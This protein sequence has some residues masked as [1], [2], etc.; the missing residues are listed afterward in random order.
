MNRRTFLLSAGATAVL[1]AFR[2]KL[3]FAKGEAAVPVKAPKP[4][5]EPLLAPWKGPYGGVP[6]FDK[7]KVKDFKPALMKGMDLSRADIKAIT[8]SKDA[9]TFENTIAAFEDSGRHY[10]RAG[11][12]FGTFTSTMNDK[13]MQKVQKEMAPVMAAFSDEIIQNE[14]LFARIKTVYDGRAKANLTP[15]Q[16]RLVEKHYTSFARQGAALNKDQKAKLAEINKKLAEAF[17]A[18]EQNQLHDEESEQ[19]VIDK[20]EDLAGLPESIRGA[21]KAAADAKKLKGKWVITNTRSSAEPFLSYSSRRDLREKVFKMWNSRGDHDGEHDNKPVMLQILALR[22]ERAKLLGFKSHAHWIIDDNMAKTPDNAMNLMMRVWKAAT[23]RV[24]EEVADM[25][26]IA[27]AEKANIKIEAWDYRYYA[28]KVRK[29]KYD[30]DQDQIKEYLQLDKLREAMFWAAG[31]LYGFEFKLLKDKNIPVYQKD[32]TVYEVVRDGKH[33]G[34]WYFDP[35]ARA[36]KNSG[37]WMSEYR[38]QENF[39]G[40]VTPIVSN[41]CNYVRT[42]PGQP[43][44]ISWD[45]ANTMFHEFGHALHGLNS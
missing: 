43:V 10:G 39:K 24:K 34:L 8:D 15:E 14:A 30:L 17:T 11:S 41:N 35:Y 22:G 2:N 40:D 26:K 31:Q 1:L 32:M 7:I 36:G 20:E 6:P 44:L 33:V 9:A 13:A 5:T 16:L 23:G 21:M 27:D 45:D 28:E 12:M 3:S 19:I 42:K 18:F 38:T 37:A 29:A 4:P 25:Q